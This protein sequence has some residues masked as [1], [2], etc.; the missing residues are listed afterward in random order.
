M[1]SILKQLIEEH[2][3]EWEHMLPFAECIVRITPVEA[4]GNRSPYQI[5]TGLQPKLPRTLIGDGRVV[6]IGSDEYVVKLLEYLRGCYRS[7]FNQTKA[8]R[9]ADEMTG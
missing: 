7:V 2:P 4:L 1:T 3:N 8:L 6:S 9:E 5:V